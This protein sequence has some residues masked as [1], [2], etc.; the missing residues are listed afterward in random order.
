MLHVDA[1]N[2]WPPVIDQLEV[3]KG[4]EPALGA[5]L[6]DDL[7]APIE[8]NAPMHWAGAERD[9]AAKY[10]AVIVRPTSHGIACGAKHTPP[11]IARYAA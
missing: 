4:F 5:A 2:L 8:A 7:D 3:S 6:G 9:A 11:R 1:K 10:A